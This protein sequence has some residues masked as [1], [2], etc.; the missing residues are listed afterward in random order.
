MDKDLAYLVDMITEMFKS[1]RTEKICPVD[2]ITRVIYE[3][4]VLEKKY[5]RQTIKKAL[6]KRG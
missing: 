2:F 5:G 4:R 1:F 6:G 3:T